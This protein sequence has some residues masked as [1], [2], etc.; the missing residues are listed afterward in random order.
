MSSKYAWSHIIAQI[1]AREITCQQAIELVGKD[2]LQFKEAIATRF[3][4]SKNNPIRSTRI[5]VL[6]SNKSMLAGTLTKNLTKDD[7]KPFSPSGLPAHTVSGPIE[8]ELWLPG[9]KVDRIGQEW[10]SWSTAACRELMEET[11]LKAKER[12]L[13]EVNTQASRLL[14]YKERF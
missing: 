2:T 7:T 5:L 4:G 12:D 10:E 1:N 8:K 6:D 11:G 3:I 9:G 13:C 14:K